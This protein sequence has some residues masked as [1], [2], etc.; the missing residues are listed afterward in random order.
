MKRRN[1][2]CL[3]LI[4]VCFST[5][6]HGQWL[7]SADSLMSD[8]RAVV[9]NGSYLFAGAYAGVYRSGDNGYSWT[10]V[11]Q[12]TDV[13]GMAVIGSDVYAGIFGYGVFRS[14]DNGTHW[15]GVDSG[16]TNH[17]IKCLLSNGTE[18]F[19]GATGAIQRSTNNG[20]YWSPSDT[21]IAQAD[22]NTLA[23]NGSNIFAGSSSSVYL[24]TNNGTTWTLAGSGFTGSIGALQ[25]LGAHL[26]AA[27]VV[28]IF[29]TTDNGQNWTS[30][31]TGLSG[32]QTTALALNGSTLFTGTFGGGIYRSTD[33]GG[34]WTAVNTGL[35]YF[36]IDCLYSNGGYL[37]AGTGGS[38]AAI[39][40]RPLSEITTSID[41]SASEVPGSFG[42]DQNYPNP[43]NPGTSIRYEVP[44][45][46]WVS[47][48]VYNAL[49]QEVATLVNETRPAGAFTARFDAW[50]LASGV[51]FYRLQA[52]GFIQAKE[53]L[54]LK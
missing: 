27:T 46:S 44:R 34:T 41:R 23:F 52:G 16:L 42:L 14:T 19:T 5:A 11:L 51:Y 20:G 2:F 9:S 37:Y 53:M 3:L 17:N 30:A 10:S 15:I 8:I 24:S 48:K 33:E 18:L 29:R 7:Q 47:L 6:V 12:N 31:N 50:N 32:L 1:L 25:A 35:T 28:G 4:A 22:I 40:R 38:R 45:A 13:R 36:N 43:F 54:L 21:S 49:G 39:W 26:F